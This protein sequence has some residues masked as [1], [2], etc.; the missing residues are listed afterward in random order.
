MAAALAYDPIEACALIDTAHV[1]AHK[2][3]SKWAAL[4]ERLGDDPIIARIV[5]HCLATHE[6][7]SFHPEAT[8]RELPVHQ[9]NRIERLCAFARWPED[10]R[11]APILARWFARDVFTWAY[12]HAHG[13]EAVFDI[14]AEQLIRIGDVRAVP[15]VASC[16]DKPRA[17]T[18]R[19]RQHQSRLARRI[20]DAVG[21]YDPPVAAPFGDRPLWEAVARDP[22]DVGAR[23]VLADFLIQ[24]GD[25]RGE[26]IALACSSDHRAH[27]RADQLLAEHWND[28]FGDLALIVKRGESTFDRGTLD[29]VTLGVE[30][31]PSWAF[32]AIAGHRELLTVRRVAR[33]FRHPTTHE[34]TAFLRSLPDPSRVT[35]ELT[36]DALEEL[37]RLREEWPTRAIYLDVS[38]LV[39]ERIETAIDRV[40]RLFPAL[41]SIEIRSWSRAYP[42]VGL[43]P[44]LAAVPRIVI[45]TLKQL[46]EES[47]A[48]LAALTLAM[49]N[50]EVITT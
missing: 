12:P 9:R 24:H 10:P 43:I 39:P 22:D 48:E 47:K 41:A 4:G 16:I 31:A 13:V 20:V 45:H 38:G 50:V 19:L 46:D 28:W 18:E 8:V 37:A 17:R 7:S 27:A 33:S 26:H 1:R 14:L 30:D 42:Y 25:G 21:P 35:L 29:K 32:A 15:L 2:G 5:A 3:D 11:V 23:M 34:Y 49:P 36:A 6:P 44:R 40:K